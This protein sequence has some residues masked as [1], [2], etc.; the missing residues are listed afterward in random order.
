MKR[1]HAL[2][3]SYK[4]FN[5]GWFTVSEVHSIIIMGGS[6]TACRQTWCL[7]NPEFY[8]LM[9]R[10]SEEDCL[11]Q[12]AR[13]KLKFH[14]GILVELKP[15]RPQRPPTQRHNP[16]N[17]AIPTPTR[18]HLL[19]IPLP[20]GQEY[21][22]FNPPQSTYLYNLSYLTSPPCTWLK[23]PCS[24]RPCLPCS[25]TSPTWCLGLW[26][27]LNTLHATLFNRNATIH[28][29]KVAFSSVMSPFDFFRAL[30]LRN[31]PDFNCPPKV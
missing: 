24:P 15:R 11:L 12:A 8:V 17:K 28:L 16:F 18:P 19:I 22:V 2:G 20:M 14:T 6:M 10:Q 4:T 7:R 1:P 3:N 23:T 5:W 27:L 21:S 29:K 26:L 9:W 25:S 13:R 30:L 31:N